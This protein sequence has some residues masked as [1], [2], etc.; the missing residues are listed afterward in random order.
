MREGAMGIARSILGV[1]AGLVLAAMPI[2]G[3]V[4]A[5]TDEAEFFKGKTIRFVVGFGPGGGYDL[6]ARMIAPALSRQLGGTVVVENQPGAGGIT[7]LNRVFTSP[8]DGLTMMIANGT[9]AALAQLINQPGVRFDI[10]KVGHLGTVS[11]EP[12]LWLVSKDSP[13]KTVDD[14]FKLGRPINWSASGPMDGLSD[15]ALFTCEALKLPCKVITGYKGSRE[16][17]MAVMRNEMDS[18]YIADTS[19]LNYTNTGDSRVIASINRKRS[20]FYPNV[21]TVFEAYRVPAENEWMIDFHAAIEDLSRILVLPP[22]MPA[23]RLAFMQNAAKAVLTDKEF[24][25]EGEKSQRYIHFVDAQTTQTAVGKVVSNLTEEQLK[26]V[27]RIIG[28]AAQ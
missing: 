5:Q 20:R 11:V 23:A 28:G 25:A 24:I 8:P 12:W 21:P 10:T 13:L 27:R 19:A 17:A 22:G 1:V 15:G 18:L 2:G 16:A 9:G 6:Y 14:A 4:V 7:A 3:T 26:T